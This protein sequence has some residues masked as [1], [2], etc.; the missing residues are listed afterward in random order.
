MVGKIQAFLILIHREGQVTADRWQMKTFIKLI[1]Y[2]KCSA[3]DLK[4]E[5]MPHGREVTES[6]NRKISKGKDEMCLV[7]GIHGR[8]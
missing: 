5:I 2:D 4:N 3:Y 6:K 1:K 7:G 8:F